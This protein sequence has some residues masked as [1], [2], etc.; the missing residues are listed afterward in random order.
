[1]VK[2]EKKMFTKTVAVFLSSVMAF[3][4]TPGGMGVVN[5][6]ESVDIAPV[7]IVSTGSDPVECFSIQEAFTAASDGGVIELQDDVVIAEDEELTLSGVVTLDLNGCTFTNYG[8][9]TDGQERPIVGEGIGAG[10][11]FDCTY[12]ETPGTFNNAGMINTDFQS[13]TG[14]TF[15]F[16]A[17]DVSGYLGIDGGTVNLT[18]GCFTGGFMA[19]NGGK[20]D[21]QLTVSDEAMVVIDENTAVCYLPGEDSLGL[22]V[23]LNGGYYNT[24][25]QDIV[26]DGGEFED[27]VTINGEIE[28]FD[29]SSP[30][31]DWIEDSEGFPWRVTASGVNPELLS[32]E[33]AEIAEIDDK[34]YTG[35]P[36]EPELTVTYKGDP[37]TEGVDYTVSYKNNKYVGNATATVTGKGTFTGEN[38]ASFKIVGS[39]TQPSAIQ[40]AS[41][42]LK[43]IASGIYKASHYE[44]DLT[45]DA[46]TLEVSFDKQTGIKRYWVAVFT[47]SDYKAPTGTMPD[48][49]VIDESKAYWDEGDSVITVGPNGETITQTSSQITVEATVINQES[50]PMFTENDN[51]NVCIAALSD[52]GTETGGETSILVP[53]ATTAVGKTYNVDGEVVPAKKNL[54]DCKVWSA[55]PV[56]YT[57]SPVKPK[58]Y[59]RDWSTD[60]GKYLEEGK[61]FTVTYSNNVKVGTGKA[62]VTGKGDYTGENTCEFTIVDLS[63]YNNLS[64]VLTSVTVDS[65]PTD[66]KGKVTEGEAKVTLEFTVDGSVNEAEFYGDLVLGGAVA[67]SVVGPWTT[68]R[69][70]GDSSAPE[71]VTWRANTS[72]GKSSFIIN[73]PVQTL[74]FEEGQ[75]LYEEYNSKKYYNGCMDGDTVRFYGTSLVKV[76]EK[77]IETKQVNYVEVPITKDSIGKTFTAKND[78]DQPDNPDKP[79]N[80]DNPGGNDKP[81]QTVEPTP[82]ATPTAAPTDNPVTPPSPELAD[83]SGVQVTVAPQTYTGSALTPALTV[84]VGGTTL[85]QGTDYDVAYSDNTNAGTAKYVLTGKGAYTGTKEGTFEIGKAENTLTAKAK[86]KKHTIKAAKIKNRKYKIKQ[87]NAFKIGKANGTVTYK[88]TKGNSGITVTKK[89]VVS[90][91]KGLKKG[92]YTVKVKVTAGGDANHYAKSKNVSF[93]IIIK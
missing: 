13:S 7:A 14:D 19:E 90:V 32:I 51:M 54:K 22:S 47:P 9:I 45:G 62:T 25:P 29:E 36:I 18:G 38:N 92:T 78:P 39:G 61:D 84:V 71:G 79:D 91:K 72:A 67:G 64:P 12:S 85:V 23:I 59:V 43:G 49:V 48:V 60:S 41:V 76:G 34:T 10:L 31:S 26:V 1:M 21:T 44:G 89:G 68:V 52:E 20:A 15:N 63:Q 4:M 82:T 56:E 24:T 5:A 16:T 2:R 58:V 8:T 35:E 42:K 33:E 70:S 17:G 46:A 40:N 93:K 3:G 65:I 87:K 83:I 37:L 74:S 50:Q 28:Q 77:F 80:P 30:Q 86:K 6:E 11:I 75:R 66:S 55:D 88:K 53:F 81:G 27:L 57:G 69:P 73:V